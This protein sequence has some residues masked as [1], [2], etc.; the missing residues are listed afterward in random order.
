MQCFEQARSCCHTDKHLDRSASHNAQRSTV[1]KTGLGNGK[2]DFWH[3][4]EQAA[5]TSVADRSREDSQILNSS[6]RQGS[7]F[8]CSL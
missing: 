2:R 7:L 5:G 3:V 8:H 1:D 6:V 4:G